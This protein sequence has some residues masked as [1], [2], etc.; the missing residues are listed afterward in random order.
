MVAPASGFYAT[1]G[2]G[3]Q[4]ARIA[5]VLNVDALVESVEILG[6]ALEKYPRRV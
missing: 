3:R 4:E 2:L 5:Y 1:G 6:V